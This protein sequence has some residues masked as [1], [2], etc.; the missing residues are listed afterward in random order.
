MPI[1]A[2]QSHAAA[3]YKLL[4]LN[5]P[6]SGGLNLQDLDYTLPLSQSPKM[7]NMM[8]KNGV[9][10]KR[11]GQTEV[12][13]FG[14]EIMA[15]AKYKGDLYVQTSSGIY[16]YDGTRTVV[17]NGT[18]KKGI[19][20]SF[21][22]L[23]YFLNEDKYLQYDGETCSEVEPYAPDVCINRKPD[24][25]YSD[26]IENY[27]RLGTSFKNTFNGDGTSKDYYLTMKKL[28]SSKPVKVV[29]GNAEKTIGTDFTVNYNTGVVTFTQAPGSGQNN[30][31]ITANMADSEAEKYTGSIM[32]CKYALAYGGN[33]SSHL[34]LAGNGTSQFYYSGTYDASYFPEQANMTIGSTE[35]DI[36]G[37]GLQYNV[38]IVFKPTEIYSISYNFGEDTSGT[39]S[40]FLSSMPVNNEIGCDMPGTIQY[41]DNRLT[42]G[43]KEFGICTLC[44]TV[45]L[46][47]RNV[48]VVSRNI[49]GGERANGLLQEDNL[50]TCLAAD[51]DGKYMLFINR[52]AYMWDYANA[53]FSDS[54]KY[55]ADEMAKATSWYK[56]DKIGHGSPVTCWVQLDRKFYFGSG[57]YL[58]Q[59]DNSLNDFGEAI[60]AV[61]Q[62]PM[63]DFYAYESLK[64]IKKAF[65]E[66]RADTPT[67]IHI[68]YLTDE[69]PEGETDPEDI[70]VP[71]KLWSSFEWSTF[72]WTF[73]QFAK[74]F[75]RKCSIKKVML[76]GILLENNQV[77][78]DMSI[79]G[80]KM[81]YTVVKE[82]K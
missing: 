32:K 12:F 19:F 2:Q 44:S 9:F 6:G 42:W 33:N 52:D 29:V 51:Y 27:N 11:Y 82:I 26:L 37:F 59:F 40:V 35:D 69:V 45:I 25:S 81:E 64:T 74:T 73:L 43:S 67:I 16:K 75:A 55:S 48:R 57:S 70:N 39:K 30:V 21:N 7:L 66:V 13:D 61:F 23:L 80:I 15:M 34:F 68:T 53:P 18:L 63:F 10:G 65:F 31:V 36:T 24:G 3:E 5:K 58:C 28:N 72:G 14:S 17:Y 56:W 22:K 1:I 49:N 78:R 71:D 62:T 46:D 4:A 76:F 77:N 47:E 20:F 41:I 38:L 60:H 79:S 8:Y 54:N 50:E